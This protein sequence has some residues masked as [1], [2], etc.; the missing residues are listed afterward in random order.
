MKADEPV[1]YD[2]MDYGDEANDFE[3]EQ[4]AK[5]MYGKSKSTKQI[6]EED[7]EDDEEGEDD[8]E[9][10]E[11]QKKR[12]KVVPLAKDF[13]R[14]QNR[15]RRMNALVGKALEED[16]AFWDGIGAEFFGAE[17]ESDDKDFKSSDA[18]PSAA[19]DSFDTDFLQ[20]DDDGSGKK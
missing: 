6:A 16:D 12:Q 18:D 1:E 7:P 17:E 11:P 19:E 4:Y 3:E 10:V 2:Q 13:S 15:G 8:I 9:E 20:S 5:E 14:R